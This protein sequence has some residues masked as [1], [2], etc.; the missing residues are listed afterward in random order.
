MPNVTGRPPLRRARRF[1]ANR[2]DPEVYLGL[3]VTVSFVVFALAVWLFGTLVDYVLENEAIVRWDITAAEWI[4]GHVTPFGLRVFHVITQLGSPVAIGLLV[5]VL[6]AW[7]WRRRER[8]LA[9]GVVAICAG[10]ALLDLILKHAIHRG[11][12]VFGVGFLHDQQSFS[13]PSGHAF[14]SIV[15]YGLLAYIILDFYHPARRTRQ[16]IYA[17][18]AVL[19]ASIGVSRIYLGVHYPSDVIGGFAAGVAWLSIC[20]TGIRLARSRARGGGA[21]E[22]ATGSP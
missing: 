10:E 11:R 15:A 9:V 3:H 16:L 6:A 12:P 21:P 7:S 18:T 14:G 1:I 8:L 13:F 4:H 2:L 22:P 17:L 19:V 20:L 5:V